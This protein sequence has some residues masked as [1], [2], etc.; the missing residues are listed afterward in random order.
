MIYLL[1]AAEERY[2]REVLTHAESIKSIEMLKQQLSTAQAKARDNLAATET[3]Q[4]KL[5]TSENSWK[6][7]KQ[8]LDQEIVDLNTRCVCSFLPPNQSPLIVIVRCKDLSS[9]NLILHQHL[10]SVSSQAARIQQAAD[11]SATITVGEG[12]TSDDVETKLSELRAVVAYLRK[13]KEIV[14][15]QLEL[16]KQE[17]VRFKSQIDHLSQSL[18]ETRATLSEVNNYLLSISA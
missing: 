7:Q 10:E 9:Q 13:E 17:N 2:S 14:D 8:T 1:Q 3:A 5:A 6:Q 15:L 18:D 11:S 12:E 4:V 16:S